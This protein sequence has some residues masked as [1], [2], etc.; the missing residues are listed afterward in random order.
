MTYKEAADFFRED[1]KNGKCSDD[2]PQCNAMVLAITACEQ[3]HNLLLIVQ[4]IIHYPQEFR[5]SVCSGCEYSELD[6][7]GCCNPSCENCSIVEEGR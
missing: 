7:F 2:C 3:M 5:D 6:E 1:L 4:N